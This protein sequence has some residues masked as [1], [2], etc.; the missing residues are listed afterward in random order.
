MGAAAV[1]IM[2]SGCA[3]R[4]GAAEVIRRRRES[5][6]RE[7]LD[8]QAEVIRRQSEKIADLIDLAERQ[9]DEI[10]ALKKTTATQS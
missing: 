10:D 9:R 4:M 5:S 3:C 7:H 6:L 8:R 2:D 1:A